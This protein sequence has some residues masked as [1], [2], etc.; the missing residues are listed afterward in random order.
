M[1]LT[2]SQRRVAVRDGHASVPGCPVSWFGSGNCWAV[3][4]VTVNAIDDIS[5][6]WE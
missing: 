3:G 1:A 2:E 4:K 6:C 5:I